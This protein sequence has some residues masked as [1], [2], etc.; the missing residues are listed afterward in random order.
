[1]KTATAT[2]GRRASA[3]PVTRAEYDALRE[4]LD[5]LEDAIR[6]RDVEARS[7]PGN[8]LP[9][10]L[11]ERILRGQHPVRIW[12]AH[13]GLGLNALAD[14]AKIPSSYLS[15]IENRKKPGS[16]AAYGRLASALGVTIDDIT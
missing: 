11:V 12:R 8:R 13:R 15:A 9:V 4:R 3:R 10:E 14:K 1:M 7:N 6:V 2:K 5:D 16:V